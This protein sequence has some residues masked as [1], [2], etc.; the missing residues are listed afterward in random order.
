M[1]LSGS[2]V[3]AQNKKL[4]PYSFKV[5]FISPPNAD[6]F[7]SINIPSSYWNKDSSDR[8]ETVHPSVIYNQD[9]LWG[10]QY[11]MAFTPYDAA[12]HENPC[13][14]VSNDG[15]HWQEFVSKYSSDTLHNPLF[16]VSMVRNA[17]YLSDPDI[18]FDGDSSL[19]LVFRASFT[20]QIDSLFVSQTKDGI[21][22]SKKIGIMGGK[23]SL[24]SPSIIKDSTGKFSMWVV[25]DK[26]Q[27]NKVLK[28]TSSRMDS[29]W[30]LADTCH[31]EASDVTNNDIWHI[32][33]VP[34]GNNLLFG[35]VTELVHDRIGTKKLY[36]AVSRDGGDYW[37]TFDKPLLSPAE[38]P[39]WDDKIIY[40]SSGVFIPDSTHIIMDLFYSACSRFNDKWHIG[41][42]KVLFTR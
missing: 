15:N 33:V 20:H 25:E 32:E 1:L 22:W 9:S 6:T 3:L 29:G 27:P 35:L 8:Y 40:R 31:W 28:Y 23:A 11:W 13:I 36:L 7:L 30:T 4:S 38:N 41:R 24:I 17:L 19:W 2:L 34:F 18:L 42:T 21:H 5:N 12:S 14:V 26:P 10:Y 39:A 37:Q 16:N